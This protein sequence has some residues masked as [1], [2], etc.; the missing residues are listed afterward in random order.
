[1]RAAHDLSEEAMPW[2]E[3]IRDIFDE[4][5]IFIDE[6]REAPGTVTRAEKV[7]TRVH[8]HKADGWFQWDLGGMAHACESD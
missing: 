6:K 1:M 7:G 8:R 4:P 3:E 5:V 2:M